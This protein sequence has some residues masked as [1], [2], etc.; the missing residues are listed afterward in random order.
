MIQIE[1]G[2]SID[3]INQPDIDANSGGTDRRFKPGNMEF[4]VFASCPLLLN[5]SASKRYIILTVLTSKN[6][7]GISDRDTAKDI[8][9][10]GG[11]EL[12]QCNRYRTNICPLSASGL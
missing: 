7:S 6:I 9:L 10:S 2:Q 8:L 11:D 12:Y 4:V 5:Q 1:C 3:P